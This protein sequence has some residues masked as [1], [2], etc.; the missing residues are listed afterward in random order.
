MQRV[1]T[2][3]ATLKLIFQ[4]LSRERIEKKIFY[5]LMKGKS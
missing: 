4:T 1:D 3:M 5:T 2:I